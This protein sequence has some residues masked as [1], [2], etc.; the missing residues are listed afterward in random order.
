[1]NEAS[2]GEGFSQVS[3]VVPVYNEV[4]SLARL[5]WYDRYFLTAQVSFEII[6]V[7]GST[8]GSP[9]FLEARIW[10]QT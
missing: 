6:C 5:D 8:D 7:D 2:A 1:L 9:E 3:V 4:E 10:L